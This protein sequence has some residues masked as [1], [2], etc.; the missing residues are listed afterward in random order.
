MYQVSGT[1]GEPGYCGE[2]LQSALESLRDCANTYRA[3][4]GVSGDPVTIQ[5]GSKPL[6]EHPVRCYTSAVCHSKP[7]G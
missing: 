3:A 5:N 4:N 6:C 1:S 7:G 2:N